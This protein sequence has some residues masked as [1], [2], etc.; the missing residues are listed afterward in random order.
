VLEGVFFSD[1]RLPLYSNVTGKRITSGEEAKKL[2]LA[3]IT[4]PVRWV[5]EEEAII[6]AGDIEAVLETGPGKVLQG[7]WK[8]TESAIP[9]YAAGTAQEIQELEGLSV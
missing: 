8:D 7:L 2:A 3:Q 6:A 1:P 5:E 4:G 9:C